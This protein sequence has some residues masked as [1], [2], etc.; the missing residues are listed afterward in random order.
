MHGGNVNKLE[1]EVQIL[2]LFQGVDFVLLTKTW[3]FP[4][5][6]LPHVE[7]CDSLVVT[8]IVEL[9]KTNVIKH[10][11]GLL[12]TFIA[13]LPQTYHSEKKEATIII[14]GYELAGVLPLTCLSAWCTLPLLAPNT[15]TNP[16]SKTWQ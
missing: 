7:E 10:S 1:T 13:T 6:Q 9:G 4:G 2:E 11:G 3:H 8:R 12:L 5:Q 14:Y 15:K 16:C